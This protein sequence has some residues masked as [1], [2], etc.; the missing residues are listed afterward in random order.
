MVRSAEI[1]TGFS[2]S[3]KPYILGSEAH[4]VAPIGLIDVSRISQSV[5]ST[6]MAAIKILENGTF[7]GLTSMDRRFFFIHYVLENEEEAGISYSDL[8]VPRQTRVE[9][10]GTVVNGL[11]PRYE[12]F[13][14]LVSLSARVQERIRRWPKVS[15]FDYWVYQMWLEFPDPPKC[16]ADKIPLEFGLDRLPHP[17]RVQKIWLAA[18][19]LRNYGEIRE[20]FKKRRESLRRET[21]TALIKANGHIPE[22]T[23]MER[24]GVSRATIASDRR[25]L[26]EKQKV[27]RRRRFLNPK[28][29]QKLV[30]K[31]HSVIKA[32]EAEG[33][34]YTRGEIGPA[35][36]ARALDIPRQALT[37]FMS[38]NRDLL[39]LPARENITEGRRAVRRVYKRRVQELLAEYGNI[40]VQ[41]LYDLL[42]QVD[43]RIPYSQTTIRK[44]KDEILREQRKKL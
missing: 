33:R 4:Q 32:C 34:S 23:L 43:P 27:P 29:K 10:V 5:N 13:K 19:K 9:A 3:P 35:E 30:R 6:L 38:H 14:G 20:G 44:F 18:K 31:I 40:S 1:Y 15:E 21:I 24:F 16:L 41:G 22:E 17:E 7:P 26:I 36:I 8:N 28:E 11:Y 37:T 2:Q 12:R 42:T 39:N 25:A